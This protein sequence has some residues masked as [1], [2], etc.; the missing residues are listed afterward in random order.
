MITE[1]AVGRFFTDLKTSRD[2][3]NE[4]VCHELTVF[5]PTRSFY[6]LL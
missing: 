4:V 2:V 3:G 5:C 6:L 1:G